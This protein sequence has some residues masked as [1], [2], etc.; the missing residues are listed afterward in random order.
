MLLVCQLAA[1]AAVARARLRA[2]VAPPGAVLPVAGARGGGRRGRLITAAAGRGRGTAARRR[3]GGRGAIRA[4]GAAGGRGG[5][6][7]RGRSARDGG[8]GD[9]GN[10]RWSRPVGGATRK[11][12]AV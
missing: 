4:V 12:S 6:C 1:R 2:A 10:R 9:A 5:G 8:C 11:R 7:R 3:R